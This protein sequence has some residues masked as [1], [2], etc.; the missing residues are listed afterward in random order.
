M[1][2]IIEARRV[3]IVEDEPLLVMDLED[4]LTGLGHHVIAI[5]TRIDKALQVAGNGDFNLAFL[6]INISGSTTFQVAA[7]LRKRGTPFIFISG[8][9]TDGLIDG[10][11]SAHL[12][13]KPISVKDLKSKISQALSGEVT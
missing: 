13:T 8:Y 9:G 2:S 12:L 1:P 5:A 4:M 7:L 3:F 6:D 11:R 10:Y